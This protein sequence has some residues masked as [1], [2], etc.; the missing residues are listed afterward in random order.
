MQIGI[1]TA[2]Y[3]SARKF[4]ISPLHP[5]IQTGIEILYRTTAVFE[6]G[7]FDTNAEARLV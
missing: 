1:R 2:G 5:T 4:D 6:T 7:I 3:H